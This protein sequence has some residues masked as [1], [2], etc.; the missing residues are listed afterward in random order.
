MARKQ[1]VDK[2]SSVGEFL[3]Y[4]EKTPVN[5][6]WERYGRSSYR[7]GKKDWYGTASFPESVN[8]AEKGWKEGLDFLT[9]KLG[10]SLNKERARTTVFEV[11]GDRPD[12]GRFLSGV[13]NNMARRVVS[14]SNRRPIVEIVLN[15]SYS[16]GVSASTIMYYGAAICSFIDELESTGYSVSLSV[17]A[18]NDA[19]QDGI[20]TYT[21]LVE[22]KQPGEVMELDRLIFFTAHPSFLRRFCFGYWETRY[23][24]S[25]FAGGYGHCD[26]IKSENLP[27]N[28]I[29]FGMGVLNSKMSEMCQTMDGARKYVKGLIQEQ[30]KDLF[31][32]VA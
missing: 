19:C 6:E 23:A 17:G 11:A 10:V 7:V 22:V 26:E 2:F 31:L 5:P 28:V 15:A 3:T 12:I 29:Y 14:E 24:P 8:L 20:H 30:R 21:N 1:I 18:S 13:P 25:G 9:S 4:L 27:D 16:G 32:E